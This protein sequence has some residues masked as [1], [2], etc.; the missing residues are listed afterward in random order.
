MLK[1]KIIIIFKINKKGLCVKSKFWGYGLWLG[2][3]DKVSGWLLI[4]LFN[5]MI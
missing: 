2:F 3:E 5:V 1:I 4:I